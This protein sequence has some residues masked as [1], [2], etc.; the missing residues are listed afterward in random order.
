[1]NRRQKKISK[2]TEYIFF[3][4]SDNKPPIGKLLFDLGIQIFSLLALVEYFGLD[5]EK[6]LLIGFQV[7]I[8]SNVSSKLF[9]DRHELIVLSDEKPWLRKMV[10]AIFK[11]RNVERSTGKDYR[12]EFG[13]FLLEELELFLAL[14]EGQLWK[15]LESDRLGILHWSNLNKNY[16]F[17]F[18]IDHQRFI[19][20]LIKHTDW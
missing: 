2:G 8:L 5:I 13:V 16:K 18:C 14:F 7:T 10:L 9:H 15:L 20:L 3:I 6:E 11:L 19:Q 17:T 4:V 12:N 1:M